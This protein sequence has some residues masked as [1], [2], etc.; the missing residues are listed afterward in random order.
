MSNTYAIQ[1]QST[2]GYLR[3]TFG[4]VYATC[5]CARVLDT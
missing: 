1:T 3:V 5:N 2:W 4:A